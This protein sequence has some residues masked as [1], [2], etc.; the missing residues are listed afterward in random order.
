MII[1]LQM[2]VLLHFMSYLKMKINLYNFRE[3]PIKKWSCITD[4]RHII[5]VYIWHYIWIQKNN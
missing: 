2:H 5:V 3:F 4:D 1:F